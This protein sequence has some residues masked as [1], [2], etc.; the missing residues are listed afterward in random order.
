MRNTSLAQERYIATLQKRVDTLEKNNSL[1]M[2]EN[3]DLR[4]YISEYENLIER[5]RQLEQDYIL[6][7]QQTREIAAAC[8]EMIQEGRKMKGKLQ[9]QANRL[10]HAAKS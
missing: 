3:A 2:K 1:L 8:K 6:G 9:N 10:F 7:I 4:A 5:V